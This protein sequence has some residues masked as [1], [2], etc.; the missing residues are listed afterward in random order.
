MLSCK[1]CSTRKEEPRRD[2]DWIS[3]LRSVD[4]KMA[5]SALQAAIYEQ[6][7][8]STVGGFGR[9][10]RTENKRGKKNKNQP[11]IG[12]RVSQLQQVLGLLDV[13]FFEAGKQA[14]GEQ[15]VHA[16]A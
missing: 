6:A 13:L 1:K 2:R 8:T 3:N 11:Q 12:I 16:L 14:Q 7:R 15:P 10:G 9:E 5:T 4:S